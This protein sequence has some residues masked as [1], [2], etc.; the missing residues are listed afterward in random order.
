MTKTQSTQTLRP[1]DLDRMAS[2]DRWLGFGYIG[3]R[4]NEL[5]STDHEAPARPDV[6]RAADEELIEFANRHGLTYDELFA[7]ANSKDGRWFADCALGCDDLDMA[8]RYGPRA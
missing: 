1:T 3:G 7:W 5:D 8:R 4:R 2:D 6:V